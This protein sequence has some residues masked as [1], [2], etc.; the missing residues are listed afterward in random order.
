MIK[1]G[2]TG[3]IGSGKTVVSS[4]LAL[5]G[6]P[7]YVAD[8]ESKRLTDTSPDIRE[9]LTALIDVSIYANGTLDRQR[10]ASL[11]FSDE[12]LLKHVNGIIHPVVKKDFETWMAQQSAKYCA[13][14][15]A[16]LYESHFDNEVDVVLMVYAPVGLRL[17][18]AMIRDGVSEAEILKRMNRQMS[19]NLIRKYADYV[20]I[21]DDIH[22]IIPQ[23]EAFV[24]SLRNITPKPQYDTRCPSTIDDYL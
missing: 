7:V 23:V 11:I 21:N 8:D 2:I 15:S 14:E 10:L 3:G 17:T 18:R 19:D 13:L 9:K 22:P 20:I 16:I 24:E 1:I 6:I 12:T 4:L 5:E